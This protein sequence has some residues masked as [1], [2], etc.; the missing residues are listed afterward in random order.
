VLATFHLAIAGKL[1]RDWPETARRSDSIWP[2]RCS[3][4]VDLLRCLPC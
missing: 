1:L 3:T 4:A 2:A